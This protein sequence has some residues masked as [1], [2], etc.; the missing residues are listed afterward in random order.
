MTKTKTVVCL[1]NSRKPSGRCVAGVEIV[2]GQPVGWIRPVSARPKHEVSEYERQYQDGSDPRVLDV[3][4]IPLL[5][6]D[7]YIFQSENWLIDPS[8]YWT[9]MGQVGW[10]ELFA[11]NQRPDTLWLN[12][13]STYHGEHDR[14]PSQLATQLPDSLCL[15]HVTNVTLNVHAPGADFGNPKRVVRARF[16][17]AGI[18][19]AL[20]VTDPVYEREYLA[21]PNGEY[22]LGEAFLTISLGE[23]HDDGYAYKLV[24]AIIEQSGIE[25]GGE[26]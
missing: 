4:S 16:Q 21:Q 24:A 3:V 5:R 7:P 2:D 14:V 18:V 9:R 13:Y 25:A 1:A 6:A 26:R 19:Y 8:Y 23:P 12:G 22:N 10:D 11:L 20:R 15:I 17:H